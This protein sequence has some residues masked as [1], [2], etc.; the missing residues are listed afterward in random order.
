MIVLHRFIIIFL[1]S[2]EM[3]LMHKINI[4]IMPQFY[5]ISIYILGY[6]LGSVYTSD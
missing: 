4:Y 6:F 3:H 2:F 5:K 1:L